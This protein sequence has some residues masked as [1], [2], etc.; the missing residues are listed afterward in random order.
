[1]FDSTRS[2]AI[3]LLALAV[4][5]T[6]LAADPVPDPAA[7]PAENPPA[8]RSVFDLPQLQ[9]GFQQF[10]R[11]LQAH[12]A[13]QDYAAAETLCRRLIE[14]VPE[15][16]STWYNLACAQARQD[17][18]DDAVKSL[19]S[20][21]ERGFRDLALLKTDAD[22]EPLRKAGRLDELVKRAEAPPAP[23][24][25][26]AQ[27]QPAEPRD[28]VV[29]VGETNTAWDPRQGMFVGFFRFD[30]PPAADAP[31]VKGLG[32]A[33]DLLRKWWNEG[34]AAGNYGDVYD[35]HDSDH[36]NMNYAAF[37]QLARIEFSDEVKR[38]NLHHG[39]QTR[40]LFNA[41]TIGNSSTAIT[42][43]TFWRSQPRLALTNP[44]ATAALVVQYHA[45]HV[46]VYPEHRDHD[47]GHNGKAGQGEAAAGSGHGDVYAVNTP[48]LIISQGS[49]GS[50]RDFL[51]ALA[52]AL[53]ALRPEVKRKL[54]EQR[55][56]APTLQMLLR[57]SYKPV[58]EEAD[59]LTGKAHP[60][61]FE[62]SLLDLPR[63]VT[64]AQALTP[65]T[66]PPRVN[67]QVVEEAERTLGVDYFHERP[68]G[69]RLFDSPAAIA[70]VGRSLPYWR[71][72][73][74]SAQQSID[75]QGAA[76]TWHWVLLRGDP[77]RV[78]IEPRNAERSVADLKIAWHPR[79]PVA[80]D[81]NLESN[82]VDIGVF[83]HNGHAYSAPAF[84][85][86]YFPDNEQR[87]YSAD[88]RLEQVDYAAEG[89]RNN[90]VDP[91]LDVRKDWRD[92]YH[93]DTGGKLT[94]WTRLRGE[95]RDQFTADGKL[96]TKADE[97]GSPL[98]T[99]PVAYR[100]VARP[101][102]APLLEYAAEE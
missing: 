64:L 101:N 41:V 5:A 13:A 63:M 88:G 66:L 23:A 37:P 74:V 32:E 58:V 75:P 40:F 6:D 8:K 99:R 10:Q 1:M 98:E 26:P 7:A 14:L 47:P 11:Q 92:E 57:R 55:A 61:V 50:D 48:Y 9:L 38:R 60:T 81:S 93:Y 20:A 59:Y 68:V 16:S 52:A 67:L 30:M 31:I 43:G 34:T 91:L 19:E 22:L 100:L 96:I 87:S 97:Q 28:G 54:T 69:E 46:Y 17:K 79:R 76:L 90:Y 33:G 82:R 25:E 80:P 94:G 44:Q 18:L 73:R 15:E 21:V 72:L 45:N 65:D 29:M 86:Y 85:T 95:R 71:Q 62:G 42:G 4:L 77:E 102:A 89:S 78:R 39:L 53:A 35:N 24:A 3:C 36:S 2:L 27:L 83:A 56:I 51:N 84:V 70:R 49:S 12:F